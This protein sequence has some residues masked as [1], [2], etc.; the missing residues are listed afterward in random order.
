MTVVIMITYETM[1]ISG[2]FVC[3]SITITFI[4]VN[5]HL[6]ARPCPKGM[7]AQAAVS[8]HSIHA[9]CMCVRACMQV[10]IRQMCVPMHIP[11]KV[12]CS[13]L[14]TKAKLWKPRCKTLCPT[15][16]HR[17]HREA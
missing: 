6:N 3:V 2:T 1:I 11:G 8:N 14:Y 5:F 16:K 12:S 4:L 7:E 10:H 9:K 13:N 15:E 17:T